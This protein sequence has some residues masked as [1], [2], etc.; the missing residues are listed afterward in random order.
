VEVAVVAQAV[1]HQVADKQKMFLIYS[2]FVILLN[3]AYFIVFLLYIQYIIYPHQDDNPIDQNSSTMCI[4]NAMK[5]V[6]LVL[7]PGNEEYTVNY[8]ISR[9]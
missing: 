9:G 1:H 5:Q 3:R 6:S 8:V 4:Q 7:R 2:S